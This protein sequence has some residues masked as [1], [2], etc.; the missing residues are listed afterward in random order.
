ML[1]LVVQI[2][3]PLCEI[4]GKL[5]LFV[6]LERDMGAKSFVKNYNLTLFF[7]SLGGLFDG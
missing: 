1:L 2:A 3:Y 6:I 7:A 4:N 5:P